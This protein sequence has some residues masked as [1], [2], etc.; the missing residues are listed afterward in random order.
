MINRY[1]IKE[2]S[3]IWSD[4]TKFKYFFQVEMAL[5]SALA[6]KKV[7]PDVVSSFANAKIDLLRINELESQVHHDVIAFTTSISEQVDLSARK[8]FHFGCTSSDI[9]DS[10]LSLQMRDS[11]VIEEKA[12]NELI[13]SL[14]L[15][16]CETRELFTLGRS[17]GMYA[18]PMSFGTKFLSYVSELARRRDELISFK[19]NLTGQ[20]SGAVGNYTVLSPE[21][22]EEVMKTLQLKIEP[23][24]TQ[25]IP[26][27]HLVTLANIQSGIANALERLAIEIRHLHR[28]DVGEVVEG[29]KPGQKGSS[30]MPHKKNPIASENISGLARV[31]RSHQNI[32]NENTLLWHERDISHSS[33]ERIW[34]PDSFGLCTY[35]LRRSKR[36][37]DE[38]FINKEV[39]TNKTQSSFQT[40]SSFILHELILKTNLTREEIYERVQ[41]ISF[42][43]RDLNDFCSQLKASFPDVEMDFMKEFAPQ[44]IYSKKVEQIFQRVEKEII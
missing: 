26:R 31:I 37:I 44:K 19:E 17:H 23:V 15:K 9:I 11:I 25:V 34:L 29:F 35:I 40:L 8:Y 43:A 41:K 42:A 7:I 13:N 24:S 39:I 36:M 2:I 28:S 20:M 27:D 30:T 18:E 1:E 4:E 14:W 5:L 3:S 10:A 21:I 6:K 38:L 33:S 16:A 12:L 22:E 32:A